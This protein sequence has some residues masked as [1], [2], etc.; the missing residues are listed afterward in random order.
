M[1][2]AQIKVILFFTLVSFSAQAS[3][4]IPHA[5]VLS[6]LAN[7]SLLIG[8]LYFSQRKTIAKAFKDKKT[9]FLASVSAAS[10]S[11]KE[12]EQ[13]LAEVT[14]R[15]RDIQNTAAEQIEKAQRDAQESFRSQLAEAKNNALKIKNMAQTSLDFEVQKQI[16]ALRVE[17]FQK[18]AGLAEKN[19]EKT[20]TPEQ[21]KTWNKHFANQ[22]GAH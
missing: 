10:N 19:L 12:A 18:S 15:V 20:L 17:T 14:Q 16:E 13:K 5:T 3:S 7:F 9:N 22:E 11:K 2:T 1:T 21:L 6:Q 4:A 8:L